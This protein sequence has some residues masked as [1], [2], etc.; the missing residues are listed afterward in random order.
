[1][2]QLSK[3]LELYGILVSLGGVAL[4]AIKE[5]FGFVM[6]AVRVLV[7]QWPYAVFGGLGLVCAHLLIE[8]WIER[9]AKHLAD[10]G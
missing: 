10:K 2:S 6:N 9:S 8:Q 4:F 7:E 3:K 5:N 1:M